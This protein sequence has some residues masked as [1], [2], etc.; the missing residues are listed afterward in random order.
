VELLQL[1]Q[2]AQKPQAAVR[3]LQLNNQVPFKKILKSNQGFTIIEILIALVLIISVL[4]I[5]LSDPFST[6]GNLDKQAS[7]IERAIR[8]MGDEAAL[9]NSVVR[10][11]FMITKAPQEYAVEYGPSDSFILPPISE[12]ETT[13]VTKEE[14]EKSAKLVRETNMKFNKVKEFQ[15]SNTEVN[16]GV[17]I[18]GI[19]NSN[20]QKL[21]TTGDISIYAFPTGEKD[22]SIVILGNDDNIVS[23][24]INPFKDK[25]EKKNFKIESSG[26][27]D[28]LDVQ[29]QKAKEIFETW[30]KDK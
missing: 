4:G 13:T 9:R 23:L 20:S 22:D 15:D 6:G 12:F 19:G 28:I 26:N 8:F 5:T 24:E 7:D 16:D 30:L 11:H 21:K 3:P 25:V 27:R 29:N 10:L 17:K 18:I 14:E 2:Q 1:V